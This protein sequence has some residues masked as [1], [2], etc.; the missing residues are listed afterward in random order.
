[1]HLQSQTV[2]ILETRGGGNTLMRAKLSCWFGRDEDLMD[3][4]LNVRKTCK[5]A[6]LL[7]LFT[8]GIGFR[9]A[10]PAAARVGNLI[11]LSNNTSSSPPS[12]YFPSP[13]QRR[14]PSRLGR[15][16]RKRS[17]SCSSTTCLRNVRRCVC[18]SAARRPCCYLFKAASYKVK[19]FLRPHDNP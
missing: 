14:T 3:L 9:R 2:F 4:R 15:F 8:S 13:D 1:M 16:R 6:P 10:A 17:C 5:A 19:T 18:E 11:E 12:K 7:T